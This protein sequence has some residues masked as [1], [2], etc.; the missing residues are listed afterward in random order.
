MRKFSDDNLIYFWFITAYE[1]ETRFHS[2]IAIKKPT[3]IV[4]P[5]LQVLPLWEAES[6]L[7][8]MEEYKESDRKTNQHHP[9]CCSI[10][11]AR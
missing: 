5:V 2:F 9:N 11:L 3:H 4:Q 7:S 1:L 6:H 8:E 10:P